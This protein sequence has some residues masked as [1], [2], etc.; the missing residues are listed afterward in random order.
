MRGWQDTKSLNFQA[1]F[2]LQ[3]HQV[4]KNVIYI[5]HITFFN[6]DTSFS[7]RITSILH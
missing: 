5:S 7:L 2:Y 1:Y 6:S 4:K 3:N